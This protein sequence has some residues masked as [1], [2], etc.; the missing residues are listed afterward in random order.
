MSLSKPMSEKSKK[1]LA[2][3]MENGLKLESDSGQIRCIAI[4]DTE[5]GT[6]FHM[7]FEMTRRILI[8]DR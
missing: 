8:P 5:E 7:K 2:H 3:A 6:V 1:Q 4:E